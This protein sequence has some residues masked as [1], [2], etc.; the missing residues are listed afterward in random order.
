MN[1]PFARLDELI[2]KY[3][4]PPAFVG[5]TL[6]LK[7]SSFNI[8]GQSVQDLWTCVAYSYTPTG[9]STLGPV[10][11]ALA[12]GSNLDYGLASTGINETDDFGLASDAF[13]TVIDM[14]LAS[15]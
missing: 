2:F 12:V 8:F 5:V 15:A 4:L 3:A 7:F 9:A 14:G 6:Y 1:A 11:Q 10:A 13:V